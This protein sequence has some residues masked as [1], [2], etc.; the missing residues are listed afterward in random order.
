MDKFGI[1]NFLNAFNDY[2]SANGK[3][4][5][6]QPPAENGKSAG[7]KNNIGDIFSALINN[8]GKGGNGGILKGFS[9]LLGNK[10]ESEPAPAKEQKK[11]EPKKVSPLQ[12]QMLTAMKSHDEFVKRVTKNA[13]KK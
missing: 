13:Q 9:D 7:D 11:E 12:N 3:E 6:T 5:P 10:K 2:L 8:G 4:K 1:F